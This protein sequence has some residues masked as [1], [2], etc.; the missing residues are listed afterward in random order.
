MTLTVVP[1]SKARQAVRGPSG[2]HPVGVGP[3]GVRRHTYGFGEWSGVS[4]AES[5]LRA[6]T[7]LAGRPPSCSSS[8]RPS[9]AS[10]PNGRPY[11]E[12]GRGRA[13]PGARQ[14]LPGE[15]HVGSAAATPRRSSRHFTRR[16]LRSGGAG[17]SSTARSRSGDVSS[18]RSGVSPRLEEVVVIGLAAARIAR[19]ISCDE[20]TAPLRQRLARRPDRWT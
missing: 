7:V 20:I 3:G 8:G 12:C 18:P 11:A 10:G 6:A 17:C 9:A 15:Q 2:P 4:S 14:C 16:V 5:M 1:A 13:Q 19:A